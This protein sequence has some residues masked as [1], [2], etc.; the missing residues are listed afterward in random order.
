MKH[1]TFNAKVVNKMQLKLPS[2]SVNEGMARAAAAAFVSQLDPT[3]TE[4]AD[5]KCAVSEAVTNCI[6]HG[7]RDTVGN[8]RMTVKLCQGRIVRI[9]ISDKGCGIADVKQARQPLFTTD[10]AGERSGMG[11]TVMESFTDGVRVSSKPGRGTTVTM[12][13]V[14]SELELDT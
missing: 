7:Y 3:A 13:K 1:N 2:L 11:F 4:L 12:V 14:L 9:E 10:A 8:V 6:V 5:I